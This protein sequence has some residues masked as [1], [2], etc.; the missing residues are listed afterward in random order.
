MEDELLIRELTQEDLQ[1]AGYELASARDGEEA[2]EILEKGDDFQI[3]FTDIRMPG[4]INGWDLGRMAKQK[5]PD[6]RII[7]TSGI[8]DPIHPLGP[9][10]RHVAKPYTTE[11]VLEVLNDFGLSA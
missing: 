11:T 2:A 8:S 6:I 5:N 1:A 4:S 3:L 9:Y 10:E 7:Y